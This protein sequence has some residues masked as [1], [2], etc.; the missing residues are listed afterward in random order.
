MSKFY[1][2]SA[3]LSQKDSEGKTPEIYMSITNRSGGKTFFFS[4]YLLRRYLATGEPFGI[5]VR[6][7]VDIDMR[8][9]SFAADVMRIDKKLK[10]HTLTVDKLGKLCKIIRMDDRET[11]AAYFLSLNDSEKIRQNSS[12]LQNISTLFMDEFQPETGDYVAREIERFQ[13]VHTSIARGGGSHV[14]RVPVLMA[15]NA[16]SKINPYFVAL[17]IHKM[18]VGR[19]HFLHGPGWVLEQDYIDTAAREQAGSGFNRAFAGTGYQSFSQDN[20]YLLDDSIFIQKQPI[21]GRQLAIL[22]AD[23]GHYGL[24]IQPDET[25]YISEKFDPSCRTHI[26][27][28]RAAQNPD[29]YAS[30]LYLTTTMRHAYDKSLVRFSSPDAY[31][32]FMS[33]FDM[34]MWV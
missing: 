33:M 30:T 18:P 3:L 12:L 9:H 13:S 4:R 1:D 23:N 17:G 7:N 32:A 10:G 20:K 15:S 22:D 14:R 28:T 31:A 26:A 11:P 16:V 2:G 5:L 27:V 24:W 34:S 19:A 8:A 29:N 21:T 25:E 6:Y